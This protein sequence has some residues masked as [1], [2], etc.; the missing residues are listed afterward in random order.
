[1]STLVETMQPE[2]VEKC[3]PWRNQ[4]DLKTAVKRVEGATANIKRSYGAT[5]KLEVG[6]EVEEMTT[7]APGG[8]Q[9]LQMD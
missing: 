3:F 7:Q 4:R 9:D 6:Q 5:L 1:M 2:S 8:Q